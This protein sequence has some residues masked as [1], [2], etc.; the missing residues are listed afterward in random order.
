LRATLTAPSRETDL[1]RLRSEQAARLLG[2]QDTGSLNW[3]FCA[4]EADV[5]RLRHV[6][7]KRRARRGGG[8]NSARMNDLETIQETR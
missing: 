2:V 3:I 6:G 5:G 7:G 4:L 8:Q 1:T